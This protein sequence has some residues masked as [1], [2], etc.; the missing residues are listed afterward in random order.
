MKSLSFKSGEKFFHVKD[1]HHYV[2]KDPSIIRRKTKWNR[3]CSVWCADY[4]KEVTERT[5]HRYHVMTVPWG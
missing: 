4:T 2:Y 3:L 5:C 1:R